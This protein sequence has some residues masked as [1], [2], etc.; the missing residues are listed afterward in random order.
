M[1]DS[2]SSKKIHL[3]EDDLGKD[4]KPRNQH[5]T[6]P[7]PQQQQ[8][9]CQSHVSHNTCRSHGH[10][11]QVKPRAKP[12][13]AARVAPKTKQTQTRQKIVNPLAHPF[14]QDTRCWLNQRVLV[15][16]VVT[17]KQRRR[18]GCSRFHVLEKKN[19]E[20]I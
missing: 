15:A 3:P 14:F 13:P 10:K 18:R 11:N 6:Q 19:N 17:R 12:R 8:Q 16:V 9:I 7:L 5:T 20:E 2:L 4:T 1:R